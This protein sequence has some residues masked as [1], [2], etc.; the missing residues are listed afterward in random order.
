MRAATHTASHNLPW[1]NRNLPHSRFGVSHHSHRDL[2]SPPKSTQQHEINLRCKPPL[3]PKRLSKTPPHPSTQKGPLSV[4]HCSHPTGLEP[5][6]PAMSQHR[7]GAMHSRSSFNGVRHR[8]RSHQQIDGT[9]TPAASAITSPCCRQ[10]RQRRRHQPSQS[11]R[12]HPPHPTRH[13]WSCR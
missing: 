8:T 4:S 12:Y 2:E 10:R 1:N 7:H 11:Q 5:C 13:H 3:T 9:V 6:L